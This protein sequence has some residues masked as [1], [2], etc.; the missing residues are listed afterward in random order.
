[1][2]GNNAV[3]ILA[4]LASAVFI[5]PAAAD[6][7]GT[8]LV[9][10]VEIVSSGAAG[11]RVLVEFVKLAKKELPSPAAA[12][13]FGPANLH[14]A[15]FTLFGPDGS[16]EITSAAALG[17]VTVGYALPRGAKS[18]DQ[19]TYGIWVG[20]RKGAGGKGVEWYSVAPGKKK[21]ED[22]SYEIPA[23]LS[24]KVEE[25]KDGFVL[26]KFERW[27]EGDPLIWGD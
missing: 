26:I 11:G 12:A 1:M 19:L 10:S 20:V 3:L 16:T 7:D 13:I 25:G 22:K 6:G 17:S 5:V 24:L 14:A 2:K 4:V 8:D 15:K 23:D 18:S 27:P 21:A 9:A